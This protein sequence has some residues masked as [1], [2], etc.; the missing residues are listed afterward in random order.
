MNSE[1]LRSAKIR[2]ANEK[3]ILKIMHRKNPISQSEVAVQT[4]LQA[5]TVFRIFRSLE[6]KHLIREVEAKKNAPVRKGRKPVYYSINEKV[7]YAI[8]IDLSSYGATLLIFDFAGATI[9]KQT[10]S[11]TKSVGTEE[12]SASLFDLIDKA[13]A[14]AGVRKDALLGIGIGAPGIV[15]IRTG[16]VVRYA[17][18]P[19]MEGY[20]LKSKVEKQFGVP[21]YVHNNTSV[22]ALSE[23]RYGRAQ[24]KNSL[25]AF[26]IRAG[27]G[28]AYINNGAIFESQGK[29]AFEAG[30]MAVDLT[31][32]SA[33]GGDIRTVENYMTEDAILESVRK[34][35]GNVKNWDDLL[36]LLEKR[37]EQ[38]VKAM[39]QLVD[40]LLGA[41]RNI[42][43]LLN[44]EVM[45]IIT[46]FRALSQ[47]IADS[48]DRYISSSFDPKCIDT[49][50]VIPLQY[51]PVIACKGAADFV[52]DGY[53]ETD[54]SR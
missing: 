38:V 23:Y 3:M 54:Y 31:Q 49:H 27:V 5:S 42:A 52:F 11:F 36:F 17:R 21:A 48:V 24:G 4:G 50:K 16:T 29:T 1:P 35:V 20:P 15:D 7:A 33:N 19:G 14:D 12:M 53:F 25:I 34:Q 22:I 43:L 46:R 30:H 26:L 32:V 40:T 18:F 10:V 13:I 9:Q 6:Q 45:L 39:E 44:P 51:D 41:T 28:G 2:Q 37:D 47:F 8:G